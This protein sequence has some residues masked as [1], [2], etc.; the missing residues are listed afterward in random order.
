MN[1]VLM[2][3]LTGERDVAFGCLAA[4]MSCAE[5]KETFDDIVAFSGIN[6]NGDFVSLPMRTYSSGMAARLRFSIAAAKSHDLLLIAEALATGD[7]AFRPGSD[8]RIRELRAEPGTVYLV[9]HALGVVR[10]SCERAIW[11]EQ[12]LILAD[13]ETEDMIDAYEA[14]YDP[15]ALRE[16]IAAARGQG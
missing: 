1:A 13:G 16:R 11:L 6:D 14:R 4:G 7:A 2:N 15:Q 5:V 8:T 12:G 9:S 10:E 3:D